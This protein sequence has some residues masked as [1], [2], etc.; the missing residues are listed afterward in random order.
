MLGFMHQNWKKYYEI[1]WGY[2]K[3]WGTKFTSA[4][5]GKPSYDVWIDD[6]AFNSEQYQ[7]HENIS[8]RP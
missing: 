1:R 5:L 8:N 3:G 7:Y 4:K 6:K 2:K